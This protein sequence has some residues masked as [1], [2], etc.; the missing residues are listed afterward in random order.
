M[1]NDRNE[2]RKRSESMAIIRV[3]PF[4]FDR[5]VERFKL[6]MRKQTRKSKRLCQKIEVTAGR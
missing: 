4:P 3:N 6:E 2:K 5:K 1:D